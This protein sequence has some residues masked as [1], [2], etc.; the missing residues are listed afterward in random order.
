MLLIATPG[1]VL[2]GGK[3]VARGEVEAIGWLHGRPAAA[4]ESGVTPPL[5]RTYS[6]TGRPFES[7]R[8][9]GRVVGLTGGLVVTRT[10]DRVLAGWRG[11]SVGTLLEV[12]R[13]AS[14]EDLEIG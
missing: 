10:R 1:S 3:T 9:P 7:F 12:R 2:L 5:V 8:V 4:L 14:I 11:K 13:T 6:S